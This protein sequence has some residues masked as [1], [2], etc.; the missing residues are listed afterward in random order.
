MALRNTA[1]SCTSIP[2]SSSRKYQPTWGRVGAEE[3]MVR[4]PTRN[5]L[6]DRPT[7]RQFLLALGV[8][9]LGAACSRGSSTPGDLSTHEALSVIGTGAD[10]PPMNPGVNRLA[11]VLIDPR[12]RPLEGGT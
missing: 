6:G 1:A 4:P 9:K 12:G 3:V 7:R 10:A 5:A 8:G 11:L 2:R